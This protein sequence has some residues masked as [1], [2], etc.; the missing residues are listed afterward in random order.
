MIHRALPHDSAALHVTG[1]ARY[2]DDLAEPPGTLYG[3]F[4]LS[5]EAHAKMVAMD[6]DPVR[7]APGVVAVLT[8]ADIPGANNIGPVFPDEPALAAERV[9]FRGQPIFA[10]AA[11]SVELGRRAARRARVGKQKREPHV[12]RE[13]AHE[14][15]K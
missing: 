10:V 11:T 1:E 3:A 9:E 14:K 15:K 4:G 2:V 6:L 13:G 8:A 7:K 12:S 5:T